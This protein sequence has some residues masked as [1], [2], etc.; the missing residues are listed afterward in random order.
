MSSSQVSPI[1]DIIQDA[2]EG[3]PYIL[4]DADDR[5]NEGDVIIPAQFATSAQIN[6]MAKHARGLICVAITKARADELNL[7]PMARNNQSGYETAFTV[8]I[9]ARE[10]VTTGI[11]AMDRAHTIAVAVD[12][13]KT[14]AD[15]VSPG[16]VFPLTAR[17]GGV[18]VRAGHNSV[19]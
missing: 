7:V 13:T 6:F 15:L 10:G 16:H 1:E 5:E 2:K 8:S 18:L 12:P 4:V 9:E 19:L 3:K 11:S 17:D 14:D